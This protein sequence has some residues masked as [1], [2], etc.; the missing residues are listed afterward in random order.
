MSRIENSSS[1]PNL[2][3]ILVSFQK[4]SNWVVKFEGVHKEYYQNLFHRKNNWRSVHMYAKIINEHLQCNEDHNTSLELSSIEIILVNIGG[5]IILKVKH[6]YR[7]FH[8]SLSTPKCILSCNDN[9]ADF[10]HGFY[11]DGDKLEIVYFSLLMEF[12]LEN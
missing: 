11:I 6:G 3:L 12:M 9:Y 10:Y 5:I 2:S 1:Q 8:K 4:E 7:C